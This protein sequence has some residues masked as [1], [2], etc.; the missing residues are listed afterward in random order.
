MPTDHTEKGFEHAIE[1]HLLA[2]GHVKGD[3]AAFCPALALD[4]ATL[5]AFHQ[6]TQKKEWGRLS[7]I[8]GAEA[9]AMVVQTI[10]RDLDSRGMLDCLRHGVTDRGVKLRLA[11]FRPA[12]GLNPQTLT[13]YGKNVLTV[14]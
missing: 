3:P 5:L 2:H 11:F 6:D 10:A 14:T 4:P 13:L 12:T 9:A 1:S 7:A 8:Y